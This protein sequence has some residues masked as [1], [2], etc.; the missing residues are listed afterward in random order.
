MSSKPAQAS[1]EIAP[2]DKRA[3]VI[4]SLRQGKLSTLKNSECL[5]EKIKRQKETVF[6]NQCVAML[7]KQQQVVRYLNDE[8]M[9]LIRE[10]ESLKGSR[11][12]ESILVS[13]EKQNQE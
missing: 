4:A 1:R 11:P 10:N 13:L 6:T 3:Q 9:R 7:E 12:N 5:I 8:N 2:M